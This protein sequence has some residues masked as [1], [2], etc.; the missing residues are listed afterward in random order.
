[1]GVEFV[2]TAISSPSNVPAE[3]ADFVAAF[4]DVVDIELVHRGYIRH[5]ITPETWTAEYRT[6]D[7]VTDPAS[8]VSTWKTFVVD[9]AARDAVTEV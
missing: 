3:L 4:P 9:A 7:D 2:A 5:T 8:A 6:V 1:M